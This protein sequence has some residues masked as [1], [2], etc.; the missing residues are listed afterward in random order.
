MITAIVTVKTATACYTY[1]A[2]DRSTDAISKEAEKLVGDEPFGIS[3]VV[4][5]K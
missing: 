5:R 4:V 2:I 3:V 1:D